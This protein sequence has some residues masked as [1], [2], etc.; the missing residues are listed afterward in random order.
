MKKLKVCFVGLG[1]IGSRHLKNLSIITK[2]KYKLEVHALR[3]Q[4]STYTYNLKEYSIKDFYEFDELDESYDIVFITNPTH[5]H[6]KFITLFYEK[7]DYMFIE[8]PVFSRLL[9]PNENINEFFKDGYYIAAPLRFKKSFLK[10]SEM[11]LSNLNSARIICSSFMPDWQKDRDYRLSFRS[12]ENA[13]GGVDL[14][15]IHE[16]DY[17]I[18]LFGYPMKMFK[19]SGKYSNL[20]INSNDLAI[21]MFDYEKFLIELHLD[22]FGLKEQR[23]IEVLTDNQ[24]RKLDFIN[25]EIIFS[26]KKTIRLITN[27]YYLDE[28]KYFIDLFEGKT[29]NSNNLHKAYKSLKIALGEIWKFYLRCV[30]A[31]DQKG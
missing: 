5:L 2:F 6:I 28:M 27:D 16:I 7:T 26:N 25:D 24:Y 3:S 11:D 10:F 15:L 20:E 1:S 29:K 19:F 4:K 30:H 8:K 22:F 9:E 23:Y 14:D 31:E 21:Y 12:N 17:M 13:G 18:E